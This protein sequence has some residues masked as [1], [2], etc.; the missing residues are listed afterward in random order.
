VGVR[1]RFER[2]DSLRLMTLIGNW[3]FQLPAI[4]G[5]DGRDCE[6]AP[7]SG[8]VVTIPLPG[9]VDTIHVGNHALLIRILPP[10]Q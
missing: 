4:I 9:A 7:R 10:Q 2:G 8:H 1:N 3:T 6:V 5:Q